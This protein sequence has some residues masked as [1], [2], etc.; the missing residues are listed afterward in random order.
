MATSN[1]I[2]RFKIDPSL[3]V[4]RV[5]DSER[6]RFFGPATPPRFRW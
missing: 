6:E 3:G 2:I 1:E 4:A 5:G